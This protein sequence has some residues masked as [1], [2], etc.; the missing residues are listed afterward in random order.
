[1]KIHVERA[2]RIEFK[3]PL[4]SSID[5]EIKGRIH[6]VSETGCKVNAG[7]WVKVN[8]TVHRIA[9]SSE[10]EEISVGGQIVRARMIP[11]EHGSVYELG[12]RF[13]QDDPALAHL[14]DWLQRIQQEQL[15]QVHH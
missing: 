2:D 4:P 12:I 9:I 11:E 5:G 7:S 10:Q 14:Q 1:M 15:N 6:N 3:N 8:S 13:Q